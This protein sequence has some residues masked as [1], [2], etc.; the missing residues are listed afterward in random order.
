MAS[1]VTTRLQ[2]DDETETV[3]T[4]I[5]AAFGRTSEALLAKALL[6][7]AGQVVSLVAEAENGDLVGHILFSPMSL[8][9]A[10]EKAVMGLAPLSVL[11]SLQGQGVGGLLIQ[12]G[13][14]ACRDLNIEAVMLV[15]HPRYY[16]RFGFR[17]ARD[18][19]LHSIYDPTGEAFMAIELSPDALKGVTGLAR[20]HPAFNTL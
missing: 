3:E 6:L 15:G 19:G 1:G 8:D 10:P 9:N 7:S 5:S 14:N 17:S 11:P 4:L 13:L 20:Y 18:F 12:A 2:R 16:R